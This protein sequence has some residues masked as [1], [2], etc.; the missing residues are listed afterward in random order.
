MELSLL[1]TSLV[2]LFT[3]LTLDLDDA[4]DEVPTSELRSVE[5]ELTVVKEGDSSIPPATYTGI[6]WLTDMVP[7]V[8]EAVEASLNTDD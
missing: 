6:D 8:A 4:M 7:L 2:S 5:T 3:L 1:R